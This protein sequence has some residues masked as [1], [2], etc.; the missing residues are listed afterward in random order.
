M[1]NSRKALFLVVC[2]LA[3]LLLS[4]CHTD[5]DPWPA[6][7]SVQQPTA[8][9]P[10]STGNPIPESTQQPDGVTE[11]RQPGGDEDPGLNG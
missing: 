2:L 6:G 5:S 3:A 4:A 10:Q 9:S 1:K 7:G 8:M 11:T